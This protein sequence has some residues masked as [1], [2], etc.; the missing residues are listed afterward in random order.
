MA[1]EKQKLLYYQNPTPQ[2]LKSFKC[3]NPVRIVIYTSIQLVQTKLTS[4]LCQAC[5][6]LNIEVYRLL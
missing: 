4:Y 2:P 6:M 5:C 3:L 1:K